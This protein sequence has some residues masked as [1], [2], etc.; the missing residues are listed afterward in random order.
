M[1]KRYENQLEIILFIVIVTLL[2][3]CISS[4]PNWAKFSVKVV[5]MG[6]FAYS[7]Y[8][9]FKKG[10]TVRGLILL[11]LALVF[12]PFYMIPIGRVVWRCI[13]ISVIVFIASMLFEL[14]TRRR[15]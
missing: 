9:S 4:L 15:N 13:E 12:Q 5:T 7:S 8:F 2:I 11:I 10:R 3:S 14:L 6:L 1:K